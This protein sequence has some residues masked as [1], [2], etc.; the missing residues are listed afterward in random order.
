MFNDIKWLTKKQMR[1]LTLLTPGPIGEGLT[2]NEAATVLGISEFSLISRLS[3]FKNRF[4][5][6]WSNFESMVN[7]SQRQRL[8]LRSPKSLNRIDESKIVKRF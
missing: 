6:A 5:D 3:H 7:V 2:Y 4:P 1:A 8:S